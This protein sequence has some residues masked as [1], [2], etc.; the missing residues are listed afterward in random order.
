MRRRIDMSMG[1]KELKTIG[2]NEKLL[3]HIN[4]RLN[5]IEE[6][7]PLPNTTLQLLNSTKKRLKEKMQEISDLLNELEALDVN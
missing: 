7:L 2:S 4:I 5:Q 6:D 3:E 1:L